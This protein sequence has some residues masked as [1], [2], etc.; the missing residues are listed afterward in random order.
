[1]AHRPRL[2]QPSDFLPSQVLSITPPVPAHTAAT[3][4]LILLHGLGDTHLPFS[5]LARS[6]ALPATV[7]IALRAPNLIPPLFS[8]TDVPAFHWADDLLFDPTTGAMDADAGFARAHAALDDVAKVLVSSCGFHE[9]D[10]YFLGF[11]QGATAGFGWLGRAE[12]AGTGRGGYGGIIAIGAGLPK[13]LLSWMPASAAEK[14]QTPVLLCAG[15]TASQVT[16]Q[17]TALIRDRVA[18]LQYVQWKRRGDGMPQ[19]REEMMPIMQ[20]FASRMRSWTGVFEGA[21]ELI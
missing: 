19:N 5:N 17:V 4:A 9:R 12:R 7:C 3:N 13:E 21:I 16:G 10:I 2:P 18:S 14:L 6:L 11:G 8:G 1:M 15:Q 20:F